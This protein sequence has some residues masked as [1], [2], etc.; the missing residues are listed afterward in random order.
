LADGGLGYYRPKNDQVFDGGSTE[1]EDGLQMEAKVVEKAETD[2]EGEPEPEPE[3][4]VSVEVE[5]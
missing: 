3:P 4:V 1:R 5:R 2:E